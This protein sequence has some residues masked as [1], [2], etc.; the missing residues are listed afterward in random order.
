MT[1]NVS[2]QR[3]Q[4]SNQLMV[5]F[6]HPTEDHCLISAPPEVEDSIANAI[7]EN[8]SDSGPNSEHDVGREGSLGVTQKVARAI[9]VRD[10]QLA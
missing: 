4:S 9:L 8:V 2:E 3:G 1:W 6:R 7:G 5:C 10:I